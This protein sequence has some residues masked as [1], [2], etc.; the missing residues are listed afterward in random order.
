M[1]TTIRG[2][3]YDIVKDTNLRYEDVILPSDIYET[4]RQTPAGVFYIHTQIPKMYSGGEWHQPDH[5]EWW[6]YVE[7]QNEEPW[8]KVR[9]L[10]T[11]RPVTREEAFQWCIENLLPKCFH[12]ESFGGRVGHEH[13]RSPTKPSKE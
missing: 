12:I 4:L 7:D 6:G 3:T 8:D 2:I 1:N 13:P 5:G 10:N 9:H 11:I